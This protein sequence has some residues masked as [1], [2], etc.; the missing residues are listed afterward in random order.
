MLKL[1]ALILAA[2]VIA[3]PALAAPDYLC[4]VGHSSYPVSYDPDHGTIAWRGTTFTAGRYGDTGCK[5][6]YVATHNGVT[7]DLC[8]QTKGFARLTVSGKTFDCQMPK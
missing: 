5:S 3:T 2:T 7:A 6:E 8:M 4:R 1:P